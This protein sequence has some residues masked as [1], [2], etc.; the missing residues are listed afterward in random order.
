MGSASTT[1]PWWKDAVCYQIYPAS[2]K[3][4][5]GDGLGDIPGILSKVDYLKDLGVDVI[6]VSPMFDSP[7][8]DMG[9]DISNYESVYPPYGTVKDMEDLIG[10]I[11]SRGMK[12]ILDLVIN[13]TSD[14]HAWFQESRSSKTNPKRNWY[15]WKPPRYAPDGTRLP[16]TNWRS[17]FSGSTWEYDDLTGEYYLHLFAK[18]Q[19]D[20]NWENEETRKAIYDS[21]MRFWLDKGVDGFRVDT[22]NMYSKDLSFKD[23]PIV[24]AQ[25]YV[26]PAWDNWANGP[27][28]HEFLREINRDVLDKYD[29]DLV[30]VGELP[31]TNDPKRVLDYVGS[32]DKQLSMVFQFDIVDIGQGKEQK[33][34][35][36]EWKLPLLKG[37]VGKWQ[38]FIEG[39]DGW[40]TAFCENHDQGRSISRYASD[41]P[42][43]RVHSGK[44]LSLLMSSLTGT[45]FI[46]QGQEI[47]MINVPKTWGIDS[48]QDI[49]SI[50]F[51]HT[52]AKQTN[53]DPAELE[54]I[55]KGL[56]I[57]SRD[58]ARIPMQWD[59]SDFAGFS[60]KKPWARVHDLYK[61]INV[62]Q[63]QKD[64]NSV[65]GFWKRMIKLRK[66]FREV[67][68]YGDFAGFN[69]DDEKT[70]IFGKK[71]P[72]DGSRRALVACNFT[73]EDQE[74]ELPGGEYGNV[75]F[76]VGSYEDA[77]EEER[78]VVSGDGSTRKRVL[79][80]WEGRLYTAGCSLELSVPPN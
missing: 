24:D 79:R 33:Y 25:S 11:H 67:L 28:M 65:L 31:H 40:T 56:Q 42:E 34:H 62:Q 61:E 55:M 57:L 26:Q 53:N 74:I 37:V 69:M 3:D 19:P 35:F 51:Y 5:N 70:F 23:A 41:S 52:W 58:N 44:M 36:E 15:V 39:S 71:D 30:M 22:V 72:V 43:H 68:V 9:Y 14:Q 13:H 20:L 8:V 59:S 27:R 54:Y 64:R 2:F 75:K 17:Y 4:S 6:W 77:E 49:E 46:Y 10:A 7:Q 66:E 45:L 29:R 80:P 50:N 21:A 60:T 38:E 1:T 78:G 47:G 12:I 16:P 32:G 48:Y 18:E 63:Q 73:G 76:L